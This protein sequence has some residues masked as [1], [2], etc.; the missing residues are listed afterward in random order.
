MYFSSLESR[1]D[2]NR[3]VCP[4]ISVPP[5]RFSCEVRAPRPMFFSRVAEASSGSGVKGYL[6]ECEK[7]IHGWENIMPCY[8]DDS[9]REKKSDACLT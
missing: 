8:Q 7:M 1:N 6:Y 5:A 3:D 2:V 9:F 4:R